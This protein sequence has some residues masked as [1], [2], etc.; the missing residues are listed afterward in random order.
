LKGPAIIEAKTTTVVVEPGWF[1]QMDA[2][3]NGV[4]KK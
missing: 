2:Y 3:G 1:F 4:L